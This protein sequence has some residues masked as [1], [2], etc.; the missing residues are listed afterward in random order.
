M[1]SSAVQS[2]HRRVL[3]V[4]RAGIRRQWRA[5]LVLALLVAVAGAVVL[6]SV[7]GARRT[8]SS[9]DRFR[10]YSRVADVEVDVD[11]ATA[12]Q[13]DALRRDPSVAGVGLLDQMVLARPGSLDTS[14][15]S[16]AAVDDSFG[17]EV[18]RPLVVAGRLPRRTRADELA[19]SERLAGSLGVRVGDTVT[20]ES[21]SPAQTDA[22]ETGATPGAPEG[23][24]VHFRIVGLVRL[25]LDLAV[26][27]SFGG[28]VVPTP[29]FYEE[30]RDRI[31][32]FVSSL[33]RVRA[34]DGARGI[35]D[36]VRASRRIFGDKL[37]MTLGVGA[38][39][40]GASDA[41]DALAIALW[42]FAAVAALAGAT[43]IGIVA[44]RQT[45]V[46]ER[47]QEAL[48]ALGLTTR[49][50]A[51][52]TWAVVVPAALLGAVVATA[53]AVLASTIFPVGVARQAEV[54]PGVH[55]DGLA[56][57]LGVVALVGFVLGVAALAAWRVARAPARERAAIARPRPSTAARVAERAGASPA[58]SIGVRMAL[59][60][61]RG[62]AAVPVRSA[63]LGVVLGT[64]GIVAVLVFGASLQ[65][66]VDSPRLYGWAWDVAVTGPSPRADGTHL[67]GDTS[68][69]AALHDPHFAA[70]EAV[71]LLSVEVDGRPV[72]AWGFVPDR[73]RIGPSIVAGRAPRT[74]DEV[75]LGATTLDAVGKRVGE[76]VRVRS[77]RG[78]RRYRIVGQTVLPSFS[79]DQADPIADAAAFTDAGLLRV[80]GPESA[81]NLYVLA[82]LAPG[83]RAD[84]LPRT[85][86][87]QLELATG[88]GD[89][90]SVPP[91]VERI[92]QVDALPAILAVLLAFLATVAV[93]H[94]VLLAV[95]RRR[96][97][98]AVLR[99]VG[100]ERRDVRITVAYQSSVF[101]VVGLVI[102]IPVG[103]VVGRL[104]WNAVADSLGIASEIAVPAL[105]LLLVGVG[106]LLVVNVIGA[107]AA[108]A[109][110]RDHPAT[111]LATE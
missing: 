41:V 27:G 61:G 99:T 48:E 77:F 49:Q 71:C 110:L 40:A 4:T 8:A 106:A 86:D 34:T 5:L 39:T 54:D 94:T 80:N 19:I 69:T 50:R 25:P 7:A 67:C 20:F 56:L 104:V 16:A 1:A 35:P 97:D 47:E 29:A 15:P 28:I 88:V 30:Y 46:D 100:F 62:R 105:A 36:V 107:V 44:L 51:F 72:T 38:D 66:L 43:A 17:T 31:G 63:F 14:L 111:A 3:L 65:H 10:A 85:R 32:G 108:A 84:A 11:G 24:D 59:E 12:A 89:R 18:D 60:P 92:R 76:Q 109:A 26:R 13:V 87:G 93:A 58:L 2:D 98:L 55:V 73:G 91:E 96:R 45:G 57:G 52:A 83:V 82:R 33:M 81:P 103:V 102:G 90:P 21:Y 22:A 6:S 79:V 53:V 95:R 70:V 68:A 101:A 9:L 74:G 23:P 42:V 75:A 37:L 78:T 64:L